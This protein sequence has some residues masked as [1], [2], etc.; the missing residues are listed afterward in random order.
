[1]Y[2]EREPIELTLTGHIPSYTAGTLFRTGRSVSQIQTESGTTYKVG[3]W[4]DG[5]SQVHRF[6][7]I[8]PDA[9]HPM[10]RV[11]YNS[12]SSSDGMI[13]QAR[14]TGK[15]DGIT[16]GRKYDPCM[17]L[18]Q[19]AMSFFTPMK[20]NGMTRNKGQFDSVNL[21]ITVSANHPGLKA[22][23]A[24]SLHNS[25]V[26]TLCNKTDASAYQLLDPQTLEP[27]GLTAQ[28]KLHPELTGPISATHARSDPLTGDIY[29]YNLDMAKGCIYRV[30]RAS[31]STGEVSILATIE[32]ADPAYLHSTFLTPNYVI[33][34][35]WNAFYT[36]KGLKFIWERNIIDSIHYDPSKPAKWYVV[37]RRPP[38]E[39]GHGLV[40]TYESDPFFCFHTVNAYEAPSTAEP[41]RT[42][43]LADLCTYDNLDILHRFYLDNLRSTSPAAAEFVG[44]KGDSSHSIL[45]RFR[46]PC[47]PT[48]TPPSPSPSDPPIRPARPKALL[49]SAL[50]KALSPELPSLNP[51]FLTHPHRYIYGVLDTLQSTFYDTLV[52]VDTYT[53]TIKTWSRHGHSPGEPVFV[54]SHGIR[55][56]T[57]SEED[58]GVLLSV[59]LDGSRGRSY[60][61]VLDAAGMDEIG[62]AE[63]PGVVGFGF[64]GTFVGGKMG[65]GVRGREGRGA[66]Y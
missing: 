52:K 13:E 15:L 39:G 36:D 17:S 27:I 66:E 10:G 64:H 38:S 3:H 18:F 65:D 30:F 55:R 42:D 22:P 28:S 63:V 33:L 9:Q 58:E 24:T 16:F 21:G 56:Q 12:R 48:P 7:I 11:I 19:K 4:F 29:N 32:N 1:M 31:A 40:A 44:P 61:L 46:L 25:S 49:E 35:I 60:L 57:A 45:K 62:R 34:C 23:E 43:I 59:V 14:K 6:Q 20:L 54:S 8:P 50:P 5:F 53:R 41:G 51:N 2:E 47:I 26:K 37:D